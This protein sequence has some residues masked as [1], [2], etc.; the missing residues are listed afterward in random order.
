MAKIEDGVHSFASLQGVFMKHRD[1]PSKVAAEMDNLLRDIEEAKLK[2]A[3]ETEE[4]SA[5][6]EKEDDPNKAQR[7]MALQMLM[8]AEGLGNDE[9]GDY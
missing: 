7:S 3:F 2:K 8:Q 6:D 9:E 4:D 5:E 1:D